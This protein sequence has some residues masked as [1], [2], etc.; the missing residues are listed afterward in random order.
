MVLYRPMKPFQ[1]PDGECHRLRIKHSIGENAA[2]QSCNLPVLMQ[3]LQPTVSNFGNF[4][5][6][7]I[8]TYIDG[9]ELIDLPADENATMM[10][11]LSTVGA[12]V[13]K[14]KPQLAA[15]H[16]IVTD[17]AARTRQNANQ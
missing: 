14:S 12:D 15:A 6:N 4:E 17:A 11:T 2:A 8:G 10:K 9:G 7:G 1:D 13:S 3:G 5:A 16:K